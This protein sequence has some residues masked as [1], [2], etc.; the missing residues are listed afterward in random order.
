MDHESLINHCQL[1]FSASVIKAGGIFASRSSE[2]AEYIENICIS[3]FCIRFSM[4]IYRDF[5]MPCQ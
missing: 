3:G 5:N 1:R 2:N 4:N